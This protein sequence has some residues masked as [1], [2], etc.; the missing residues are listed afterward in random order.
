MFMT[1]YAI[2]LAGKLTTA[3]LLI[4]VLSAVFGFTCLFMSS[5]YYDK[6]DE[7]WMRQGK[8]L[9]CIVAAS[10]FLFVFL[11]SREV[12]IASLIADKAVEMKIPKLTEEA[13]E[14]IFSRIRKEMK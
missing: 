2:S 1:F 9:A 14:L 10:L 7:F 11:P 4:L 12:L 6:E 13:I 8:R 5:N 3:L